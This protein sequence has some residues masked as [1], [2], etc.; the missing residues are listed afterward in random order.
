MPKKTR[1]YL[2]RRHDQ[3][4]GALDRA[5]Y[6]LTKMAETY[7]DKAPSHKDACLVIATQVAQVKEFLK[8]FRIDFM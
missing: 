3:A 6:H 4:Q 8:Q 1:D 2:I 5:S 7:D